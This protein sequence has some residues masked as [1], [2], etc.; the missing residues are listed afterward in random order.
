MYKNKKCMLSLI[1]CFAISSAQV[2]AQTITLEDVLQAVINNYPSVQAA[3]LQVEKARQNMV[4][5]E[6]QLGWVLNGSG[7]VAKDVSFFGTGI[8]RLHASG[9]MNRKLDS[10]S[11]LSFSA[12]ISHEDAEVPLNSSLPDPVTNAGIDVR[13]RKPLDKGADNLDYTLGLKQAE[14]GVLM[15]KADKLSLYDQLAAN[16]MDLYLAGIITHQRMNNLQQGIGRT[17]TLQKY[18]QGRFSLG[19]AENKDQLQVQ[20]QLDNQQAQL[21]GLNIAW[22]QQ[23]I[24]LNRLMGKPW[25]FALSLNPME[26]LTVPDAT[27]DSYLD[28]AVK[29]SPA[30]LRIKAQKMVADFTIQQRQEE[31]KDELDLLLHLGNRSSFGESQSGNADNSEMVG[32][33]SVEY[34]A[35]N[36]RRGFDAALYQARLDRGL[37]DQEHKRITQDLQYDLAGIVAEIEAINKALAAFTRS[38]SSEKARL[39]DANERYQR[40]RIDIDR[41]IQAENE[42]SAAQLALSLQQVELERRLYQLRLLRAMIWDG[43]SLPSDE[44]VET[45]SGS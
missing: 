10:G 42:L 19:I 31:R 33:I 35:L 29:H 8:Q 21:Q 27:L 23:R 32:G 20:A 45:G 17:N 12:S 40:G 43:I 37:A 36:D 5:V 24:A 15:A 38:V 22:V 30:L 9:S 25:D 2:S 6:S 44:Q 13:F 28:D 7:G 39:K 26:T 18:I 16:V 14:L 1:F 3:S 34:T 41:L 4:Q 11:N